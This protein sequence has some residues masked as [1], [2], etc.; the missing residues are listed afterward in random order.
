MKFSFKHNFCLDNTFELL[1]FQT[2]ARQEVEHN[3]C[4]H[5]PNGANTKKLR[6]FLWKIIFLAKFVRIAVDRY[7]LVGN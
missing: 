3:K 6:I 4:K 5:D 2:A 1:F 7:V